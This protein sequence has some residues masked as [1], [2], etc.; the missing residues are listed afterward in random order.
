MER[1]DKLLCG[2]MLQS[3]WASLAFLTQVSSFPLWKL[4]TYEFWTKIF[5]EDCWELYVIASGKVTVKF[6]FA[7]HIWLEW[8][9]KIY[10]NTNFILVFIFVFDTSISILNL[11]DIWRGRVLLPHFNTIC[12]QTIVCPTKN[13][14]LS[15]SG[16]VLLCWNYSML[17]ISLTWIH[18]VRYWP[19]LIFRAWFVAVNF[20]N[21]L[22]GFA[23]F[24]DI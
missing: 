21:E 11:N 5:S 19:W 2:V 16:V 7:F 20:W 4:Y 10:S 17:Y 24:I 3:V 23:C 13:D 6:V 14:A 1:Q 18:I 8:T 15:F 22:T 12:R 9:Y